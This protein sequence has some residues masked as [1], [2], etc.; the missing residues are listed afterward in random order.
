M[1]EVVAEVAEV[2]V[3]DIDLPPLPYQFNEEVR[4]AVFGGKNSTDRRMR[5]AA[6]DTHE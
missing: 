6:G 3:G 2:V 1:V 5:G 4:G